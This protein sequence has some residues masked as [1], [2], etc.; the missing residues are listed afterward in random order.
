MSIEWVLYSVDN[1]LINEI[2][3][4]ETSI[5]SS[6]RCKLSVDSRSTKCLQIVNYGSAITV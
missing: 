5:F 3:Y 2:D 1:G 6:V 4:K